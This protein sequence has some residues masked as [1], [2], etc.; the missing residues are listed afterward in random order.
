[1]RIGFRSFVVR[2]PIWTGVLCRL[3]HNI[4]VARVRLD[5]I[6]DTTR[7]TDDPPHAFLPG[8][9]IIMIMYNTTVMIA[10]KLLSVTSRATFRFEF[11]SNETRD[12]RA[13]VPVKTKNTARQIVKAIGEVTCYL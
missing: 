5:R 8:G 1:M 12:P 7:R 10:N 9:I 6:F 2:G 13:F 11:K 3:E 4:V